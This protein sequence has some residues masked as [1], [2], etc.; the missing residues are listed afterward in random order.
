MGT[1][2]T[3]NVMWEN[4]TI[5]HQELWCDD[6]NWFKMGFKGCFCKRRWMGG[7]FH[8]NINWAVE[9]YE[10]GIDDW[11]WQ[12]QFLSH[13]CDYWHLSQLIVNI[14]Q[15]RYQLRDLPH[16][17][18]CFLQYLITCTIVC[19]KVDPLG[20]NAMRAHKYSISL[21]EQTP[22][23]ETPIPII[24]QV[25]PALLPGGLASTSLPPPEPQI[26]LLGSL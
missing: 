12:D 26:S 17:L 1:W 8:Q 25:Q 16:P 22:L 4:I 9:N 21:K 14:G 15:S 2:K 20:S 19:C 18:P 13:T 3:K 23:S 10:N 5:N 7:F 11:C 24:L 6:A